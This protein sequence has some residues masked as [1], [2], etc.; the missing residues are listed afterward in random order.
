MWWGYIQFGKQQNWRKGVVLDILSLLFCMVI[1]ISIFSRCSFTFEFHILLWIVHFRILSHWFVCLFKHIIGNNCLFRL[2]KLTVSF[3]ISKSDWWLWT[4][5]FS[6]SV[7]SLPLNTHGT[8]ILYR[9]WCKSIRMKCC[10]P[11]GSSPGC[12]SSSSLW[13]PP[14]PTT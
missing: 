3:Q 10:T 13:D 6:S 11:P 4:R 1:L 7:I 12:K 14:L 8:V 5:N 9:T 2:S